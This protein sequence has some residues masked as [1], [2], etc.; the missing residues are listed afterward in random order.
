[1][2]FYCIKTDS[3]AERVEQLSIL[4]ITEYE[5]E[6][7]L[8]VVSEDGSYWISRRKLNNWQ[9]CVLSKKKKKQHCFECTFCECKGVVI[10]FYVCIWVHPLYMTN[11]EFC[12]F[13]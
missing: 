12:A 9:K 7:A 8:N 4:A 13:R 11:I 5:K 1:M 2:K 3:P 10:Q 6:D